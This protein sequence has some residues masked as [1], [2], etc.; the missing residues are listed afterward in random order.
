M[1]THAAD[2]EGKIILDLGS[3]TGF[4]S[5]VASMFASTVFCT[6]MEALIYLILPI[7]DFTTVFRNGLQYIQTSC[8]KHIKIYMFF[9]F[10][11][12]MHSPFFGLRLITCTRRVCGHSRCS[13]LFPVTLSHP[14]VF[15]VVCLVRQLSLALLSLWN[16]DFKLTDGGRLFPVRLYILFMYLNV[17][18]Y[19]EKQK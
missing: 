3:G 17:L 4:T 6:G 1:V 9:E 18:P 15:P 11:I 19:N 12:L 5:L 16:N 8:R 7:I 13:L 2:F 10:N 14:L